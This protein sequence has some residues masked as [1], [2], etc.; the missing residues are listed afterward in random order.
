M[1]ITFGPNSFEILDGVLDVK[2]E[3]VGW[4]PVSQDVEIE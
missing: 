1:N 3:V 4:G 2:V